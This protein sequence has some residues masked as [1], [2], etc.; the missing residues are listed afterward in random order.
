[1][2]LGN[3]DFEKG[4]F[5]GPWISMEN[6]RTGDDWA[7]R[8]F[9][10]EH[11]GHRIGLEMDVN[12]RFDNCPIKSDWK[13]VQ[14]L[15]GYC[16]VF[17]GLDEAMDK[18]MFPHAFRKV[19][20]IVDVYGWAW[21]IASTELLQYW[22]EVEGTIVSIGDFF[23]KDVNPHEYDITFVYPWGSKQLMDKLDPRKTVVCIAGGEQVKLEAALK[24]NCSKYKFFGACNETLKE[25]L[26][27]WFPKRKVV[28]LNHG[29]ETD[30]FKPYPMPK[31]GFIVGWAGSTTRDI[32]RFLKAQ[33]IAREA[34]VA[35][36]VAGYA[37]EDNRR[38]H[39]EMPFF[40]GSCDVFLVTS[41]TE[42]HPMV[43]YEAMACG[44]P[45]ICTRVGDVP[46]NIVDGHNGFLLDIDAPVSDFVEKIT[47]LRESPA[48]RR[49]M[50]VRARRT[51][52][53]K[54]TWDKIVDQYRGLG[55]TLNE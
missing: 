12:L 22:T 39:D 38:S 18:M 32:K 14:P 43:V 49:K 50:G 7:L 17:S 41:E 34:G 24:Y 30:L 33:E 54:W 26:E 20:F 45:V 15:T 42:A 27:S 25:V 44:L 40:Y 23:K 51:I 55:Q 46:D 52:L 8:R 13:H 11:T 31:D 10:E 48:L 4:H 3:Y 53:Q 16:M 29:V 21:D 1:M 35:L 19:L 6:R 5:N 9:L 2:E 36:N 47:L 37:E 28:L